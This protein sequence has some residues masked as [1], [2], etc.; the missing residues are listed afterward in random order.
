ME[1]I[2]GTDSTWS[3]RVWM[4]CQL[5]AIDIVETVIDLTTPDYKST[6]QKYSP[7]GQVP[8]LVNH[9]LTLH[10]SLAIAEY[11]NELSDGQLFPVNVD[12]R[13][14]ARSLCAELHSGFIQLRT[15]CPFTTKETATLEN[16]SNDLQQEL[17]RIEIIFSHAELPFM[18]EKPGVVDAFYAVLAYRLKRYGISF[19]GKAGQYQSS[20]LTWRLM[21]DAIEQ[22]T[23][24]ETITL[25]GSDK[26]E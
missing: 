18:H 14:L 17:D 7:T 13:A 10:D 16:I 25:T 20:L 4:C 24:W 6:L 3:L 9:G 15:H 19:K 11:I 8:V 1:L 5:S 23:K 12:K 22:I 26:D 21:H 2:V